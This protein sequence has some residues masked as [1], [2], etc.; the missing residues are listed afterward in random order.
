ME[1]DPSPP[2]SSSLQT[3]IRRDALELLQKAAELD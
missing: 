1:N 2:Q 3:V